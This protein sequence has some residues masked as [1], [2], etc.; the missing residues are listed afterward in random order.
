M[1][2]RIARR[3]DVFIAALAVVVFV[4]DFLTKSWIVAY[5]KVP[6]YRAPIPIVGQILTLDYTQNTGVAFS[7]LEGQG[8][9]FLLILVAIVVVGGLYWRMRDTAN[10]LVKLPFGLIIGGAIGNLFGRLRFSYVVD[11]I[12]FEIP[13]HFDFPVF[14]VAD[15]A[16]TIG[17][18]AL[19]CL[20]WLSPDGQTATGAP[21]PSGEPVSANNAPSGSAATPRVRNPNARSR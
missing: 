9:L 16:I 19:A 17:V 12:H 14:N 20:L 15:S 8:L 13:G 3:D 6:G 7:L 18:I 10:L 11:F 1:K 21:P 2:L 5:F 4:L